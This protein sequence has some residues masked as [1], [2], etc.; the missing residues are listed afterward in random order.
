LLE[1]WRQVKYPGARLVIA[2]KGPEEEKLRAFARE[3][4]LSNV[5]FRGFVP[6]H[7]KTDLWAGAR[8][9]VA[10]WADRN[11]ATVASHCPSS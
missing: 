4:R 5:E 9:L 7:A 2:G 8:F 3:K 10:V 6:A 11:G 1:A